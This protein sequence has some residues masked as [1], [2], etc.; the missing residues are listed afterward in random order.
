MSLCQLQDILHYNGPLK[1]LHG[2]KCGVPLRN[3]S[4]NRPP[5]RIQSVEARSS[6]FLEHEFAEKLASNCRRFPTIVA[7]GST[8]ISVYICQTQ[9]FV[10]TQRH[11]HTEFDNIHRCWYS[12]CIKL[13][14]CLLR[15]YSG[16]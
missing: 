11:I 2:K 5:N 12:T 7:S 9:I 13:H 8:M 1:G 14:E 4:C 16:N 10:T 6:T 15:N 3:V